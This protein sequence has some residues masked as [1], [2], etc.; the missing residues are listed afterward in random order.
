MKKTPSVLNPSELRNMK[1][2]EPCHNHIDQVMLKYLTI[3]PKVIRNFF[4][5][6]Q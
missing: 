6:P 4:R 2:I 1:V 5:D 3:L